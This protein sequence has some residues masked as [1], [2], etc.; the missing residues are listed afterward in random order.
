MPSDV[1]ATVFAPF[2]TS[3]VGSHD[4]SLR[5]ARTV[6]TIYSLHSHDYLFTSHGQSSHDYLF[7]DDYG[8]RC[9]MLLALR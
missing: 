8:R 5:V 2:S 6:T 3:R 1:E 9:A 4:Y 7:K